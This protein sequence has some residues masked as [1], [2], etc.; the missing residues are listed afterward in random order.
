MFA[1]I[2]YNFESEQW[3]WFKFSQ[4]SSERSQVRI[5]EAD[6]TAQYWPNLGS[7]QLAIVIGPVSPF[8]SVKCWAD[9]GCFFVVAFFN[10]TAGDFQRRGRWIILAWNN[11]LALGMIFKNLYQWN[12]YFYLKTR[13]SQNYIFQLCCS[14]NSIKNHPIDGVFFSL[15]CTFFFYTMTLQ[16]YDWMKNIIWPGQ[17]P[18]DFLAKICHFVAFWFFFT[19]EGHCIGNIF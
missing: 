4:L 5:T 2:V 19:I 14:C 16:F 6:N 12:Q 17:K 3:N 18:S 1:S 15:L 8:A 11:R 7:Q 9:D 10:S 13:F